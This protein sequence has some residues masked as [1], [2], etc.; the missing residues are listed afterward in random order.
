[1]VDMDVML[2]YVATSQVEWWLKFYTELTQPRLRVMG[3]AILAV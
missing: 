3:P 1:M 2:M